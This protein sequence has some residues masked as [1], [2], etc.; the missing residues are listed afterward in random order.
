[1]TLVRI[2][3]HWKFPDIG[4]QTPNHSWE[5]EGIKFTTDPV[6]ECDYLIVIDHPDSDFEVY[7]NPA[8]IW[9]LNSEPPAEFHRLRHMGDAQYGRIY[10]QDTFTNSSYH[11]PAQPCLPWWIGKSYDELMQQ[12]VPLKTKQLSWITSN[13]KWLRGH[14]KRMIF[15]ETLQKQ[16]DFDLYGK[17]FTPIEDKWDG[18]APYRYALAVENH[19]SEYYWSEK[20][21]DCFLSWC[22]PIYYGCTRIEHYFPKESL[23]CIDIEDPDAPKIIRSIMVSNAWEKNLEAIAYARQLVLNRYQYFP[24]ITAEIKAFEQRQGVHIA[25]QKQR[26]AIRKKHRPPVNPLIHS[27]MQ[28]H[29][30]IL[31]KLNRFI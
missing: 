12:P 15:L 27:Y 28:T 24:F 1:M 2:N 19:S 11:V 16:I 23:I 3:K 21:A 7:C 25:Q 5:W 8:C 10:V 9:L 22:M 26:I 30:W 13:A 14:K 29:Q 31:R 20:L 4:R 17:G 6:A 18:L